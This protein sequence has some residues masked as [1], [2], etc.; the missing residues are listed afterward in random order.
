MTD[1]HTHLMDL[2]DD[3]A[4]AKPGGRGALSAGLREALQ[5]L[6][7]TPWRILE[8]IKSEEDLR[9]YVE[10]HIAEAREEW[11]REAPEGWKKETD[12]I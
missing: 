2:A 3:Y 7:G 5:P 10:A 11:K 12:A 1:P 4:A 9:L 6:P 8:Q